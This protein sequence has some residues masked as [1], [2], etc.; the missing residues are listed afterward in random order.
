MGVWRIVAAVVGLGAIALVASIQYI[1]AIQ[2]VGPWPGRHL[3]MTDYAQALLYAIFSGPTMVAAIAVT[4]VF[5]ALRR[6]SRHP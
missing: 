6:A 3:G 1:I 4:A 5:L 2:G